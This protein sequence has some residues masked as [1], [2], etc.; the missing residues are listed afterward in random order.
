MFLIVGSNGF[1]GRHAVAHFAA[2]GERVISA[3]H[4]SGAD[5]Q[6][7]LESPIGDS[8]ESLPSGI[9]H[10]L[11]CSGLTNMDQCRRE[12]SKTNL[13]NVIH[14]IDLLRALLNRDV[15]PIFCSSDMVFKGDNGDYTE[16]DPR[17]PVTEYGCQKKAVE[18]YLLQQSQPF[19]IIRMSKLYSTEPDDPSPIGQMIGALGEGNSIRCAEDQVICPT[20]VGDIPPAVAL[21]VQANATG[22]YHTAAPQRYTRYKLGMHIANRVGLEHLVQRCSIRDFA[23]AEPRPTDNSLN[24]SKF[25]GET[26]YTFATLEENMPKILAAR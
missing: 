8:I 14:I 10:A 17:H 9:T 23:F 21:L 2:A 5:I 4:L 6:L 18:D 7:D 3:S 22:V 11:I 13:F 20:W 16:D 19:L 26:G 1:L 25:L 12:P 15:L 24:V